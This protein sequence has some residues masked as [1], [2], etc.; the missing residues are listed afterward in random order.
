M[1]VKLFHTD[2]FA[3]LR[4]LKSTADGKSNKKLDN[5]CLD[6]GNYVVLKKGDGLLKHKCHLNLIVERNIDSWRTHNVPDISVHGTLSKLESVLDL[7]QYKL[8]R[9]FLAHNLGEALDDL[10]VN[11]FYAVDSR[12]SLATND[13]EVSVLGFLFL[14]KIIKLTIDHFFLR[15]N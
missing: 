6:M 8:V 11:D 5:I 10:F 4:C 13:A 14:K 2:L 7:Q 3:G 12:L 9:G 15:R 1:M